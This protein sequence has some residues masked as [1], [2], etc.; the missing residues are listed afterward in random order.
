MSN[1]Y[2]LLLELRE[3]SLAD[4][5]C[6]LNGVY[7]R[8][9]NR[10]HRRQSHVFGERYWS[11]LVKGE[12][13]FKE[14]A[15]YIVNNPVRAGMCVNAADYLWSSHLATLG[16]RQPPGCLTTSFLLRQFGA[17]PRGARNAYRRFV[18]AAIEVEAA[19]LGDRQVPG[20]GQAG[21]RQREGAVGQLR[22]VRT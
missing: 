17:D 20:R 11:K 1:H 18:D 15:R 7:A 9:F 21:A 19:A 3:A 6:L 13:Q 8:K 22:A 4:G 2:H 5:M 12:A 14:N 16:K 10:R